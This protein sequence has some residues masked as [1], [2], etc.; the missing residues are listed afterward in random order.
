MAHQDG[1]C[2]IDAEAIYVQN[3]AATCAAAYGAAAGTA[4]MPYCSMDPVDLAATGARTLVVVRGTVNAGNWTFQRAAGTPEVSIVGQQG[5]FIA[6]AAT[7][8]LSL[9]SGEIYVRGV[10][11]SSSAAT[12]IRASGG[13]LRLD[14]AVI[15]SCSQ[16]G[17]LLDTAAFDIRN[18]SVTNSGP[19]QLKSTAWGGILVNALPTVGTGQ[20]TL[21]TIEANKWTGLACGGSIAGTGVFASGNMGGDIAP[22][23]NLSPCSPAGPGCGASP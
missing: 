23:C 19:G 12:C 11:F 21:V 13:S 14:H 1:H 6:S 3:D 5:A 20:L 22:T 4:A 15:D 16:G 9:S 10:H 17:V 2:A 8:A 18:T 7:P